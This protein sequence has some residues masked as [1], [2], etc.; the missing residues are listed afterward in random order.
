MIKNWEMIRFSSHI[1][2]KMKRRPEGIVRAVDS[3]RSCFEVIGD[4]SQK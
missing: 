1:L 4:L 3:P 2:Q